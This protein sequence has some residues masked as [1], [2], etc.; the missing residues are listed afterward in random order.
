MHII[1]FV[2]ENFEDAIIELFKSLGY[3]HYYGP[4]L[5]DNMGR[6]YSNPLYEEQLLS[7]L[8][9]INH[10]LPQIAIREAILKLKD[11]ETGSLEQK[12]STFMYYLQNGVSVTFL[13]EDEEKSRIV[14]LIDFENI[15][16]NSF[17]VINQWTIEDF[18]VKRPDVVV[19]VNGLPL[20]VIE[21]K[22]PSREETDASEAYRQL[23]NY[24]K[25]IPSLFVF[26]AFCVISDLAISKAGTITANEDRYMEWKTT[27]GSYESTQ[28][29][30]FKVFFEGLFEKYRFLDILENYLL[31]S[32]DTPDLIKIL[33][34]YH[35]FFAVRK[36]VDSTLNAIDGD[37][38][39]GVFW[40]TQGSGKSLSMVF[41]VKKLQKVL[42]SP[43]FV[44]ITDRN[45]L[46]E[47]LFTQFSKCSDFL[48][49]KS[50]QAKN[51]K[52]LIDLLNNRKAN[53]I[54]FTTMQKFEESDEPL[55]ERND[56]IVISDE[57]HRSQYGLEEKVDPKTGKISVGT[58]RKIRDSLP[59]AT[60]IGFT[61]TPISQKDRSTKEVFGNYIDVYDMTQSV[62]DGATRP[63]YYESRAIKLQLDE[64]ILT[65]ID[66]EYNTLATEAEPYTIEKSKKELSRMEALLGAPE[67][68]ESLCNDI[69][70]HYENDR[71]NLLT[72]KAMIVGYSRGIAM[73]IYN[74]ILKLRPNWNE[75]VKVVMSSS[76]N[77]KE[78][79]H[80][81]IGNKSH[82]QE[83]ANRFKDNEDPFKIAIVV[84]M[85]LTGF[86]IPS[87]AT[88]YVFKPMKDHTLMQAIARVNR[89]YGDKEGG[90]I[91]DYIGMSLALKKAM[92][93]YTNRDKANYGDM[94]IA[95]TAYPKFKEKLEICQNLFHGF[96]YSDFF[97]DKDSDKSN[98][99]R[100]SLI[101]EGVNF[102]LDLS[103]EDNKKDF[104]RESLGLKQALSLCRSIV[105]ERNRL[106]AA[107]FEAI[108]TLLIRIN[109]PGTKSLKQ[110]NETIN[111]L[112]KE[113]VKSEGV[114]NIIDIKDEI[115]L[116]D[117]DFLER[118]S[119][120]PERNLA[121]E[122]LKKLL[123]DKISVYTRTNLVKSEQFSELLKSTMNKYIN[124][125]IKTE[126]VI[127]ELLNIAN[128]IKGAENEGEDLDLTSEELAFYD[129][130]SKPKAV[131]DFYE[132]ETLVAMTHELTESLN[133]NRTIDWQKKQGARAKMRLIVKKLLKK[134]GYPTEEAQDAI[135]LVLQQC[136]KWADYELKS[137]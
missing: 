56:V 107:Y 38:K 51:R 70:N 99:K 11:I 65:E 75:K 136:E 37:G 43:T 104:I 113:S 125:L 74:Q 76:N 10:D 132:N 23:K 22:S 19:F 130:I 101:S 40:H 108:R 17:D 34:A 87:L 92:N 15:D 59:N 16:N 121:I 54:F 63:I 27:D 73:K 97:S 86:D 93:D 95:R 109:K 71:A 64:D 25:E 46:D 111:N 118:I 53:G 14:K 49:Q 26:N 102:L 52:D 88:M 30:D 135:N 128:Q 133:K 9:H 32:H 115:S 55:T 82:K 77:D 31:Y 45:D 112:L 110:I 80:E 134:Y 66:K 90:L 47:Q 60:F 7:R 61:G 57:A 48:R 4:E 2:E 1:S 98:L 100:A 106:E 94:D 18:S 58:A 33:A 24:M 96:N 124:G 5:R 89:V 62:E 35:Q 117:S 127:T 129:A 103:K 44:I 79:W 72:G 20:V 126:E 119:K 36:A 84:D 21:L 83:L 81:I 67:T 39:G 8:I 123:N 12:N 29:A 69:L 116:F 28:F 114:V 122:L 91:V 85:W 42:D 50:I 120:I 131:K 78:E 3:N 105:N 13:D 137:Y 6:D 41:Y 68:I